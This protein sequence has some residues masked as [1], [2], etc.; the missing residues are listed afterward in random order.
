LLRPPYAG[1]YDGTTGIMG[2]GDNVQNGWL[3]ALAPAGR[4]RKVRRRLAGQ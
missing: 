1:S 3:D 4:Q 2:Q